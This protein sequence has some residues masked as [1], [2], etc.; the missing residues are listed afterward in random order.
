LSP[1]GEGLS[2]K[3]KYEPNSKKEGGEEILTMVGEVTMKGEIWGRHGGKK[4]KVTVVSFHGGPE[5]SFFSPLGEGGVYQK[6]EK[7]GLP[8]VE[9]VFGKG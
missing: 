6:E 8:E 3:K 7:H 1:E 5:N 9:K 2:A 4:K